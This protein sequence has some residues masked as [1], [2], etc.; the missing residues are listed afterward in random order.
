MPGISIL[1]TGVGVAR[2]NRIRR[3]YIRSNLHVTPIEGKKR[4]NKRNAI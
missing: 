2:K 3:E 1:K 4:R